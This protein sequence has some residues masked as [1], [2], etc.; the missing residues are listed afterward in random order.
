MNN[1]SNRIIHL[2]ES[3]YLDLWITSKKDFEEIQWVN[4]GCYIM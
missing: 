4:A 2:H 3:N 1:S